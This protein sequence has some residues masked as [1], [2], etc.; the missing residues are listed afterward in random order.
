MA[1][2]QLD[3]VAFTLESNTD[4]EQNSFQTLMNSFSEEIGSQQDQNFSMNDN[5]VHFKKER[6]TRN[7]QYSSTK[8]KAR[9]LLTNVGYRRFKESDFTNTSFIIDILSFLLQNFN[10]I[11]IERKVDT[12]NEQQMISFLWEVCVPVSLTTHIFIPENYQIIADPKLTYQKANKV[13]RNWMLNANKSEVYQIIASNFKS[14]HFIYSSLYPKIYSRINSFGIKNKSQF[15]LAFTLYKTNKIQSNFEA[16]L[17]GKNP[18]TYVKREEINVNEQK[19]IE[20]EV[21]NN[22]EKKWVLKPKPKPKLPTVRDKAKEIKP[23]KF[24]EQKK[25]LKRQLEENTQ[26]MDMIKRA[27]KN[28]AKKTIVLN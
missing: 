27:K 18:T 19:P 13:V 1:Q 3:A 11:N 12:E 9:N 8:V 22:E 26:K 4:Q 16:F 14:I 5:D 10:P 6:K 7:T 23:R 20:I 17:P 2:A 25:I 28:F 15:D 24:E 21:E